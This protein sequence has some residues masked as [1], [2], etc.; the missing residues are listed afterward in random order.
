MASPTNARCVVQASFQGFWPAYH[1]EALNYPRQVP[2]APV[3]S[4]PLL[5]LLAVLRVDLGIG[6]GSQGNV[7]PVL[8]A[9]PLVLVVGRVC[10]LAALR[11]SPCLCGNAAL[12][13]HSSGL[14]LLFRGEAQA[15]SPA[16][17]TA[18]LTLLHSA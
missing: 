13:R 14:C 5:V 6:R 15:L 8:Q 9:A 12:S 11:S 10:L 2:H 17:A 1:L 16:I 18:A 3:G 4:L 7:V